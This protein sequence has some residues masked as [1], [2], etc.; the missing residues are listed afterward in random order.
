MENIA[1]TFGGFGTELN[2]ANS[3]NIGLHDLLS[4]G[5]VETFQVFGV[6]EG[7]SAGGAPATHLLSSIRGRIYF[8]PAYF[9]QNG[10]NDYVINNPSPPYWY[11]SMLDVFYA[12][13][14]NPLFGV[15]YPMSYV[16]GTAAQQDGEVFIT[17][18]QSLDFS[19]VTILIQG[20][21][22]LQQ[23]L[24]TYPAAVTNNQQRLLFNSING[25][26]IDDNQVPSVYNEN[27]VESFTL[28][29]LPDTDIAGD[30]I[31]PNN[32]LNW[33]FGIIEPPVTRK[34][35]NKH[36]YD[37]PPVDITDF[38]LQLRRPLT[39]IVDDLSSTGT[40]RCRIRF[41]TTAEEV[42]VVCY[43]L[44]TD[45]SNNLIPF[46]TNYKHAV[47]EITTVPTLG[48]PLP[49]TVA[50]P[51]WMEGI[52]DAFVGLSTAPTNTSGTSWECS[53]FID[54]SKLVSKGNYR[55]LTVVYYKFDAMD[56]FEPFDSYSFL[57]DSLYV[58]NVPALCPPDVTGY[59]S[60]YKQALSNYIIAAPQER[61]KSTTI[62]NGD[63]YNLCRP[64]GFL[65]SVTTV[66]IRI[67]AEI[68]GF[69]HVL[70][71]YS[72]SKN[73]LNQWDVLPNSALTVTE[74]LLTD[75]LFVELL[76]RI[77]Y[78]ANVPSFYT[79]NI[80][81]G[82]QIYQALSNQD[83]TNKNI[84]VETTVTLEQDIPASYIDVLVFKQRIDVHDFD[85]NENNCLDIQ[86]YKLGASGQRLPLKNF[87]SDITNIVA[88]TTTC[89]AI[90]PDGGNGHFIAGMD[91]RNYSI[92][93]F[94]EHESW[95]TGQLPQLTDAPMLT[96]FVSEDFDDNP[97]IDEAIAVID[98][99]EIIIGDTYRFTAI[100][101]LDVSTL[102]LCGTASAGG[103]DGAY[104]TYNIGAPGI[105]IIAYDMFEAADGIEIRSLP[106][107]TL[108][109]AGAAIQGQGIIAVDS[110]TDS[111][112]IIMPSGNTN[113]WLKPYCVDLIDGQCNDGTG[114]CNADDEVFVEMTFQNKKFYSTRQA[115]PFVDNP[116]GEDTF[117]VAQQKR[118]WLGV[119]AYIIDTGANAGTVSIPLRYY[120]DGAIGFKV[121]A[122]SYNALGSI[123]PASEINAKTA[124]ASA[125]TFLDYTNVY[126]SG[127]FFY[128]SG[129]FPTA[130]NPFP[131]GVPTFTVQDNISMVTTLN[132][133][134]PIGTTVNKSF[135][136]NST[137]P[138]NVVRSRDYPAGDDVLN[139]NVTANDKV[140]IIIT[141]R[142][143]NSQGNGSFTPTPAGF[144]DAVGGYIAFTP[145]A[146]IN[147]PVIPPFEPP[148]L[149]FTVNCPV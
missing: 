44:N 64:K 72:Q 101:K 32:P 92:S 34:Y 148:V 80:A 91:N 35:F 19:T 13:L 81:T 113:W 33:W 57:S 1:T 47:R 117:T 118:T 120:G 20:A 105:V 103:L 108:L 53:F 26:A 146:T 121:S 58:N 11:F 7:V 130:T 17:F 16:G 114:G 15:P 52:P 30:P 74:D 131:D 62:W 69:R 51:A 37:D 49:I 115:P 6:L 66:A 136:F 79:E 61:I 76:F 71:S 2:G 22:I 97:L 110:P 77:R 60:D 50:V 8:K 31:D 112:A 124:Y 24:N 102:K 133:P 41:N 54:G 63:R 93:K 125:G 14:S 70:A 126:T 106:S 78:E 42:R 10:A 56:P 85:Q 9:K 122:F 132:S 88:V 89:P 82:T 139:L 111:I 142:P 27:R 100:K 29:Y 149:S 119:E 4:I 147:D 25:L 38:C 96:G 128:D 67:Y 87:C 104:L 65:Q 143:Q 123:S 55:L 59:L 48:T 134:L 116:T 95:T 135:P 23:D 40:T 140:I 28:Y 141:A 46:L 109:F 145:R 36:T 90:Q 3:G 138:G 5:A 137:A 43:L 21:H 83:W 107:N 68:P 39:T 18:S 84:Y 73:I 12:T 86:F 94:K 99:E 75:R 127:D 144:N 98:A 45:G 129:Y